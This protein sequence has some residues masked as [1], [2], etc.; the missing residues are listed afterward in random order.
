MDGNP[1]VPERMAKLGP[2]QRARADEL[3][4]ALEAAGV[5]MP[6]D[7]TLCWAYITQDDDARRLNLSDVVVK[8]CESKYL[9]EYCNFELGYGIARGV[10]Q[11]RGA[12]FPQDQWREVIRRCVLLTSADGRFQQPWPWTAGI[13]AEMWKRQFDRT[14]SLTD[15]TVRNIYPS[16]HKERKKGK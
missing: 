4:A 16:H 5:Q 8:M 14:P 12:P 3:V 13:T 6:M 11:Y 2:A 15:P 1:P 10:V 9:H 7:S